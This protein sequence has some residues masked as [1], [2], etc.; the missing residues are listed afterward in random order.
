MGSDGVSGVLLDSHA[1]IW[2]VGGL[3][4]LGRKARRAA[5]RAAREDRLLVSAIS[6]WETAMLAA[7]GRL[8]LPDPEGWRGSV[9]ALGITEVSVNGVVAIASARLEGL[10]PDPADRIIV[11]TALAERATL[12][13]A[14]TRLL[15]WP[16]RLDRLDARA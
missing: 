10:H 7:K 1:V 8:G 15:A 5:E 12:V 16:G 11:A 4:E 3:A 9:L 2:L 14:D 13:T 6:F